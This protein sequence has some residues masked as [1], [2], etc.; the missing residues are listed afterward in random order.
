MIAAVAP[1][2]GHNLMTR[3]TNPA[4]MRMML[5]GNKE[6]IGAQRAYE[7]G[8]VGEVVPKEDLM[9]AARRRQ[10]G[11]SGQRPE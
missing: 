7:L 3:A 6:R 10:K 1:L 4:V 5:V 11:A 2:R 9:P 8:L